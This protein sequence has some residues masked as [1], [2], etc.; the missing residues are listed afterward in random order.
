MGPVFVS[1]SCH[2]EILQTEWL[3]QQTLI[4]LT[5][6]EAGASQVALMV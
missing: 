5:P 1:E 3:K 6:L 2:N 4:F